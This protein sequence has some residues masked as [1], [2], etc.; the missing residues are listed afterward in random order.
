[1]ADDQLKDLFGSD[2]EEDQPQT[3]AANGGGDG[4]AAPVPAEAATR[5]REAQM[6]DLF[7]S[8][9]EEDE[10][11]AAPQAPSAAGATIDYD[12]YRRERYP[13]ALVSHSHSPAS[14]PAPAAFAAPRC[15]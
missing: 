11:G 15:T 8:D 12:D 14:R 3:K 10:G 5:T 1:M 9:D 13:A 6:K 7:G 4:S 2:S